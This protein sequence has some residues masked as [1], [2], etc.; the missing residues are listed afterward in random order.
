MTTKLN[1]KDVLILWELFQNS[2]VSL[3]IIAKKVKVPKPTVKYRI[4]QLMKRGILN[5]NLAIIDMS[6]FNFLFYEIFIKIQGMP[7]DKELQAL[8][9]LQ[10]NPYLG[11]LV[12][13]GG[14]FSIHCAIFVRKSYQFY[15]VYKEIRSLFHPYIKQIALNITIDGKQFNYPFFK[16]LYPKTIET[17]TSKIHDDLL[18][19]NSI[20]LNLLKIL[21]ENS[22]TTTINI[23]HKLK[24]TEKTIRKYIKELEQK[25]IILNYTCQLHPGK[26]GY[27]FYIIT[28]RLNTPDKELEKYLTLIPEIFYIVRGAGFYDIKAEF[29]TEKESRIYEIE[30][31]LHQKFNK[32]IAETDIMPVHKEYLV[33]Y[34]TEA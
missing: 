1:K 9:K 16:E 21:S 32:A 20:Q 10:K 22:R 27:L 33:R 26:A 30:Q 15:E 23:A 3:S 29:Y 5:K 4:D 18:K 2:R 19:L 31:E 17:K 24:T 25:K 34:F 13:T 6:R 8:E 28:I 12:T 7:R 11:W 14:R